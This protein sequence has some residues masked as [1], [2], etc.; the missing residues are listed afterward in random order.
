MIFSYRATVA[1]R[2]LLPIALRDW[3][4]WVVTLTLVMLSWVPFCARTVEDALGMYS[5]LA[6]PENYTWLGMRENNYLVAAVMMISFLF[7]WTG[8][9]YYAKLRGHSAL[10]LFALESVAMG[11]VGSLVFVF[12][13]PINQFMYFQ[14]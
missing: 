4:G 1:I 12:L 9:R 13:R 10:L 5:K 3:G 11:V 6:S 7:V 14:F 2:R 8:H